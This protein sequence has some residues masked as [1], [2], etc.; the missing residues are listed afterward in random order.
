M[1]RGNEL[2]LSIIRQKE[3]HLM[4]NKLTEASDHS[5]E[6][7]LGDRLQELEV[8]EDSLL[9]DN[10]ASQLVALKY[11]ELFEFAPIG[12]LILTYDGKILEI[13]AFGSRMLG[14]ESSALVS[15]D[16]NLFISSDSRTQF[17]LFIDN[18]LNCGAISTVEVA[19]TIAE[20]L[21]V[22]V[23]LSGI[24]REPEGPCLITMIDITDRRKAEE[25]LRIREQNYRTIFNSTTEAV[26]I[27][28]EKNGALVDVNDAMI[29]M[30]GYPSKEEVLKVS[31]TDLSANIDPY[32]EEAARIFIQKAIKD[33]PQSF[34][35][36]ARKKDGSTFWIGM[37]LKRTDIGGEGRILAVGR[38]ITKRKHAE[39]ALR[40]SESIVNRKLQNLL[41]PEGDI[42]ALNLNDIVD[43]K[44][45]QDLMDDF[46]K[47]TNIG[48]A[49]LDIAGNYLVAFGNQDICTKFHRVQSESREN[50]IES[51]TILAGG[52]KVG[53]FKAYRCKN[54]LWDMVTPIMV[55]DQHLGNL[56][57]GQ[58][59]YEDE[60]LDYELFRSQSR[61]F[62]Y[63]ESEY[64]SALDRVPRCTREKVNA[65]MAFCS[66]L[67]ILISS[68]NYG[69]I[70]LSRALSQKDM[71]LNK[72]EV[73]EQK[74]RKLFVEAPLGV[75]LINSLTGEFYDVNPMFAKIADRT[76]EEMSC[77]NWMSITHPDDIQEDVDNMTLFN[78]R[79]IDGF[80]M[81]KRYIHPDGSIVWIKMTITRI[82]FGENSYPTHLCM[83]EDITESK[84]AEQ[85]LRESEEKLSTLFSAMTEMVV[86][87]ELVYDDD[88][89]V[90]DYRIIDCNH[91]FI[92]IT[93]TTKADLV[94]KLA[95]EAYQR[96]EPLFL[97]EFSS[98]GT[99]TTSR[100]FTTY[101][102]FLDKH[103]MFS[104]VSLQQNYFA[105]IITDITTMQ[106]MQEVLVAKN[107]ELENFLYIT[108]HD[109]RSP[110]VNIQGFSHRLQKQSDLLKRIITE[111][112]LEPEQKSEIEVIVNEGLPKSLKFIMTNIE[113][114]D[115][116]IN[117]LLQ[118]SRTG[119]ITL[120][121]SKLNMKQ[122][123][124]SIIFA[125][126]FQ[127]SELGAK[128][129]LG[130][131]PDCYGDENQLNQLFSNVID[132]AIKYR[133]PDRQ[134]VLEILAS[135]NYDKVIYSIRDSGIGIS[136][137][138]LGKIWD[139]FFRVNSRDPMAGEGL[140]LSLAKR[141]ADNH[142]GRI[143]AESEE[144]VGSVFFVEL[145]K[146]KF[147]N[148]NSI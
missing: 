84:K 63:N 93:G 105:A 98:V 9:K 57:L 129:I 108:S 130:D 19:L 65:A 103:L 77:I 135:I 49:V 32:N 111:S 121:I 71:V 23:L 88:G 144:G 99:R 101:I 16:F 100:E 12:Y 143:W 14:G 114:M 18:I 86:I 15:K 64:M 141:I 131:L 137:R 106:Q 35:W 39:E 37:T 28:D 107:K 127:L 33:G 136:P 123:F 8:H 133:D 116:L 62:K 22:Y 122:L 46:Y 80:K 140:G 21:S 115:S 146:K 4:K 139:V 59:F 142:K 66:K 81:K 96:E 41:N 60:L 34:E 29:R 47:L 7:N 85:K 79:K 74:F 72:L 5:S 50:C 110:L 120:S 24:I 73:S 6:I 20:N 67:S 117:G 51:D 104:I 87:Y 97:T 44:A 91:A 148:I 26:F 90:V 95:T 43:N 54:N 89:E 92:K 132:N 25:Q 3:E 40:E 38:D 11:S 48:G 27:H 125:H 36:V 145:Q 134:L 94:G 78:S 112:T 102:A 55:G 82:E 17:K 56:Y 42:G 45:L 61:K 52:V 30:Y 128:V 69:K 138:H 2:G 75:G 119:R 109:L 76:I 113:K 68:L 1:K 147:Q 53:E 124:E 13:N 126:N 10:K 70:K 58:F 31:L 83:I 118:I